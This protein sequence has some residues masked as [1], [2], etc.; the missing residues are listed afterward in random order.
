[1][2]LTLVILKTKKRHPGTNNN[3]VDAVMPIAAP[4]KLNFAPIIIH[5]GVI[6]NVA[7][8]QT[9]SRS[10]LPVATTRL[11]TGDEIARININIDRMRTNSIDSSKPDP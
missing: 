7:I 11:P 6:A 3:I 8:F 1:M 2:K 5:I 10:V 9:N 4:N